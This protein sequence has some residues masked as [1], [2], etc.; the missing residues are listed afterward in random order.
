MLSLS[1]AILGARLRHG[2]AYGMFAALLLYLVTLQKELFC[3]VIFSLNKGFN[4]WV[5]FSKSD[6]LGNKS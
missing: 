4:V 5:F 2:A 1:E 6:I 3:A